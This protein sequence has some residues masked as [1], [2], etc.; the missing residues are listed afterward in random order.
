V[1]FL[2]IKDANFGDEKAE[3]S[4]II[5]L[6]RTHGRMS[7]LNWM[8]KVTDKCMSVYARLAQWYPRYT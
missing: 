5:C 1:V 7:N 4:G 6:I 3:R 8:R 2:P